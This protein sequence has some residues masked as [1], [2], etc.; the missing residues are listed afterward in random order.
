MATWVALFQFFTTWNYY[1]L[2]WIATWVGVWV[3][4]VFKGW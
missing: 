4:I 3:A 2:V 1:W